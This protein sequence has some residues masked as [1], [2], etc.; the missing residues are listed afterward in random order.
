M[1]WRK[2]SPPINESCLCIR[3][4]KLLN[5]YFD[6]DFWKDDGLDSKRSTVFLQVTH[7]IRL[8]DIELPND[9]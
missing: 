1:K 3:N 6:G 9:L 4:G 8:K 7:W 5:L 2:D